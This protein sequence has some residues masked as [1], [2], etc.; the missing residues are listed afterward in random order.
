MIKLFSIWHFSIYLFGLTIVIGMLAGIF[1]AA[2]EGKRLGLSED[3]IFDIILYS[4]IGGIVGARLVY[5]LV[6]DPSYYFANPLEILHINAGGLSIHGGILGGVLI[7][8]WRVKKYKLNLWQVADVL[9]PALILGQAIGR[10]GCD[11]FGI[12]M[13]RPYFWGVLVNGILVHPAQVYE[14]I[15]D[16][17]LFAWLWLRRNSASY[18]GQIFVH[19]LIGFSIIRGIVEL[20]RFNPQVFGFLSV[21]HLLSMAGILIGLILRNYLKKRYPLEFVKERSTPVVM[22]LLITILL[23]AAS[24]GIYY[25]IRS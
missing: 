10:I 2:K 5:V 12:P 24:I 14:F 22:T 18:R 16:Y 4:I 17:F 3:A 19:Y 23:A 6:Y 21:S 20:F 1:L 8:V 15:L 25:F 11:V 7:G 9:A 13:V